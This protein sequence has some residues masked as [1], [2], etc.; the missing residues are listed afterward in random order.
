VCNKLGNKNEGWCY[1]T[2]TK[3]TL[4]IPLIVKINPQGTYRSD[5]GAG[6]GGLLVGRFVV[7]GLTG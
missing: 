4:Q 6:G 1:R 7:Y 3:N 5:G 2:I